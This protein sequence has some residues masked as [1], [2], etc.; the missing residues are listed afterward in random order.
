[1]STATQAPPRRVFTKPAGD[2]F[3]VHVLATPANCTVQPSDGGKFSVDTL[4]VIEVYD[5][6][7]KDTLIRPTAFAGPTS[8]TEAVAAANV[9]AKI[10]AAVETVLAR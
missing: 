9:I 3:T 2:R 1:M 10:V 4:H 7:L 6:D 5:D 8:R